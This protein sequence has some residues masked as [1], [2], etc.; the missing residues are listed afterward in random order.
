MIRPQARARKPAG[1]ADVSLKQHKSLGE[2]SVRSWQEKCYKEARGT[3]G[4]Q[5]LDLNEITSDYDEK[6][7]PGGP[8]WLLYLEKWVCTEG[9]QMALIADRNACD[10]TV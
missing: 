5:E 8:K 4:D 2:G 3:R 6:E 10:C 1:D 7:L 9:P